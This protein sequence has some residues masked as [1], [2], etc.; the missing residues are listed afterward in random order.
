MFSR[1]MA[2]KVGKL[3]YT[4]LLYE[5]MTKSLGFFQKQLK[6]QYIIQETWKILIVSGVIAKIWGTGHYCGYIK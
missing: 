4:I 6:I 1:V 3:L 5:I 2:N